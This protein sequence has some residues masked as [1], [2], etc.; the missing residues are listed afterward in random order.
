[1]N[2]E[3][4][5]EPQDR[6]QEVELYQQLDAL[7]EA[8]H[9]LSMAL[10][11]YVKN[12]NKVHSEWLDDMNDNTRFSFLSCVEKILSTEFDTTDQKATCVTSLAAQDIAERRKNLHRIFRASILPLDC[13]DVHETC[14]DFI[15]EVAQQPNTMN[16][17]SRQVNYAADNIRV[18]DIAWA[19]H[20]AD[21][22]TIK[23][24]AMMAGRSLLNLR[25]REMVGLGGRTDTGSVLARLALKY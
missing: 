13:S 23:G 25:R 20:I 12:P 7:Q 18:M 11:A 14:L 24:K 6:S 8:Q 15:Y 9:D 3:L 1:M 22:R 19:R 4:P 5:Y 2:M 17:A 16:Q 21:G 10:R